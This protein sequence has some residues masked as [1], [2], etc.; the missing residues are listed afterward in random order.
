MKILFLAADPSDAVRLRLGQELRDIRERLQLARY[1]NKFSLD[2]RESVRI[3]DITQAIFDTEPR[4]IHFSGHGTANGELCFEDSSGNTQSVKPDA[5]AS[6]FKLIADQVECVV[7]NACYSRKQAQQI[8]QHIPFVI[9]MNQAIEDEAAIAFSVGFYKALGAGRSV[10]EAYEFGCV[11][12]QLANIPK[13]LSPVLLE[14]E[15]VSKELNDQKFTH[16]QNT[17]S[18]F[19]DRFSRAFPGVRSIQTFDSP[20]EAILRLSR[21]LEAPLV[22]KMNDQEVQP[23]WWFRGSGELAVTAF[24]CLDDDTVLINEKELKIKRVIAA[25]SRSYHQ[26]FVYLEARA[27]E[28]VGIY[29]HNEQQQQKQIDKMGYSYEM[30]GLYQRKFLVTAAQHD[31]CAALIDGKLVDFEPG[32]CELRKRYLS[33]YNMLIAAHESPINNHSFD[34]ALKSTM[35]NILKDN[36]DVEDLNQ[37]ILQLPKRSFYR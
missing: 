20:S 37:A 25:N 15:K 11:E 14:K 35:D 22:V 8:A 16:Y 21:L 1:G 36:A 27:L 18:F 34:S 9:G 26:C 32:T 4:I 12:I 23:I 19:S 3:G 7:L 6:L 24:E 28:P 30:Y 31:D 17:T 29:N 2:S 5:L 10:K 13:S 33:S